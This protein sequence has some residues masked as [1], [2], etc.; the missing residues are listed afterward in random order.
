MADTLLTFKS[1]Y[2]YNQLVDE[3][4]SQPSLAFL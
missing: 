2:F 4:V 3:E 1:W